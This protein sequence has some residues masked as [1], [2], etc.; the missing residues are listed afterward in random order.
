MAGGESLRVYPAE[1]DAGLAFRQ[2]TGQKIRAGLRSE[3]QP[4]GS[5][6]ATYYPAFDYLRL[7]LVIIVAAYH[8]GLIAR[9]QPAYYALQIFFALSGWLIGG[10]LLRSKPADL[11]R[12]YF[13]RAARIW[14]PY[15]TAIVLFIAVSVS[16]GHITAKWMEIFFYDSTFV[17]DFFG[18]P[19]LAVYKDVMPLRGTGNHFW[20]IGA[21]EQFY[22]L[23]PLL[24]TLLPGKIGK[25]IWF[26][27]LLSVAALSL[28]YWHYFGSISLG[29][30]AAV[31]RSHF[32]DWH[33]TRGGRSALAIIAVVGVVAP[34]W[35]LVAYRIGEPLC[36][37]SIVLFLAQAGRPS[38]IASFVGGVSYPM[39]L[40]HWIGLFAANGIFGL[41]GWQNAWY[42][43]LSG[44]LIALAIAMI[45]Y[46]AIDGNVQKSRQHYYTVLRG[47]M[48]A[49]AGF[50]LV[51]V[52]IVG[53]LGLALAAGLAPAQ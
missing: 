44:V 12:F 48:A 25:T 19:Q 4:S 53:G 7:V 21:E 46:V 15:F 2:V 47:R 35:G 5:S 29:V 17:Y 52:G 16:Q 30:L 9:E 34:C 43:G 45:L 23:A 8:S 28:H 1:V 41:F 14:I 33:L 18:A 39:Y 40:N 38:K 31:L 32:G 6:C 13:N 11:P 27:S 3:D 49:V 10:I 37:V 24:M 20:S 36:C 26:W 22:L 50:A 42:R 51:A